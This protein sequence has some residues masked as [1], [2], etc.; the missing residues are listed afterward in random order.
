[1]LSDIG[2]REI[3]RRLI[4]ETGAVGI[5]GL[6]DDCGAIEI[7]KKRLLLLSTDTKVD[8]THFPNAFTPFEKGWSIVAA[9]LSDIA[10]MGGTPIGFLIAY[11]LPREL[12]F[13]VL[14]EVQKGI[15]ACLKEYS[16][17]FIGADTKEHKVMTLTGT[18]IGIVDKRSVL[19]RKGS[20]RGDVVCVTGTL[21]GAALGLRSMINHLG[22]RK[23][24][25]RFR[26]PV[27]KIETGKM[28]AKSG[29]VTSCMDISD[30][31]SSSL[32]ELMRAS[33]NGFK[34]NS[35]SI[36]IH[37]SLL[38]S[39]LDDDKKLETALHSG[40]EYELLF[41]VK[42]DGISR[43]MKSVPDIT[44]IGIVIESK[45]VLLVLPS[46]EEQILP[47]RGFEHFRRIE[48]K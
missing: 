43:L 9:N 32:Y 12:H 20:K 2:E 13:S 30:G 23:A 38:S 40:D 25:D 22:L 29:L 42:P 10:A 7:D 39:D 11:G 17:P 41:T 36:P 31:L 45:E 34:V 46:K 27:P 16:T 35:S 18:A 28:L 5:I 33:G 47:D 48:T 24:E 14:E 6:G 3:I 8:G 19:L 4:S 1:M 15:N 44:A 26:R 37:E 21:G